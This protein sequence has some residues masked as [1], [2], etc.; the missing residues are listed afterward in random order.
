M[1]HIHS[2]TFRGLKTPL[3]TCATDL[4]HGKLK[5]FSEGKLVRTILAS[6]CIPILF[7]PVDINGLQYVDGSLMNNL[8]I[9]P[10]ENRC[11]KI[12]ASYVDS[13]DGDPINQI[14]IFQ[15]ADRLLAIGGQYRALINQRKAD[16][17]IAPRELIRY[18]L[19]DLEKAREIFEKGYNE[20]RNVL[21]KM[22]Y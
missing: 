1:K 22:G 12:I 5:Y 18:G 16:I 4:V 2:K 21:K 19:N 10:L 8:P 3:I 20:A 9:E 14:N 15:I 6:S 13:M 7:T 17:F 11:S